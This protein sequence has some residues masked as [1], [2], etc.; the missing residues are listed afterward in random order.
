MGELGEQ[1]DARFAFDISQ[2]EDESPLVKV[3]GEL[4]MNTAPLLDSALAPVIAKGPNRLVIDAS[5]LEFA[6]SS[7]I[8]LLVQWAN[9]VPEVEL[10]QP[11]EL[12]RHVIA[13]MGL[14]D[15]LRISP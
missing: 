4:D 3:W 6:D 8:A 10:Y 2:G 11:P 13:R 9:V 5:E 1:P 12:L 7:A 15:R 14:T